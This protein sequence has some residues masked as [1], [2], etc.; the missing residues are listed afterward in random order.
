MPKGEK[1]GDVDYRCDGCGL[2]MS[3]RPGHSWHEYTATNYHPDAPDQFEVIRCGPLKRTR[4]AEGI[5]DEQ[6]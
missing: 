6:G 3:D 1:A 5:K 2:T 4:R